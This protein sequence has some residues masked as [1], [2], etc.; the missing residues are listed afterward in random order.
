MIEVI[1]RPS[2]LPNLAG[3]AW[4]GRFSLAI[5]IKMPAPKAGFYLA[6]KWVR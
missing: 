1:D 3:K 6:Q 2:A 5:N 4:R